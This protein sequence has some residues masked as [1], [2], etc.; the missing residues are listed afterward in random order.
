MG[1][2]FL[3]GEVPASAKVT[4]TSA[5]P[6]QTATPSRPTVASSFPQSSDTLLVVLP[7]SDEISGL[8]VN[9]QA[10]SILIEL[11]G[12]SV[13]NGQPFTRPLSAMNLQVWLLLKDGRTVP[14]RE[15]PAHVDVRSLDASETV[16]AMNFLFDYF[17]PTELASLVVS[18]NGKMYVR[19][20]HVPA[21]PRRRAEREQQPSR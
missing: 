7:F 5:P 4:L 3:R 1:A 9:D 6:P 11:D 21:I 18:V 17:A 10:N 13:T 20:I 14:Q 2:P 19:Q 16:D 12:Q 8:R 15:R